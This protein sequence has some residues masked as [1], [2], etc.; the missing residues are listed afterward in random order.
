MLTNLLESRR[1][2]RRSL[3]GSFVSLVTHAALITFAIRAT[4]HAGERRTESVSTIEFAEVKDDVRKPPKTLEVRV[5]PPPKGFQTLTV[6]LNIPDALPA[7]DLTRRPTN[8]SDWLGI[9]PPGGRDTGIAPGTQAADPVYF[10]TQVEKPVM[11]APGSPAPRYPELLKSA[12]VEGEVVASFVV[13]SAGRAD[14]A[15]FRILKSANA[16]FDAAVKAALP[17]MRF[18]PAEVGGR[19]VKQQVQ[20]PFVFAIVR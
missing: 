10:E 15:T 5:A 7:I 16:L 2:P 9:G 8:E 4:L 12:G 17:A 18:I 19:K 6:P 1:K 3:G 11:P 14:P 13:D 20:Q